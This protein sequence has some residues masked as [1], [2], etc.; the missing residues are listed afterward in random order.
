V[1]VTRRGPVASRLGRAFLEALVA[2]Q[3]AAPAE[4]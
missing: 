1:A 4:A 2:A 3:G